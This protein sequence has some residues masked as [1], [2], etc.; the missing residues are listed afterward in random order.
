MRHHEAAEAAW[1]EMAEREAHASKI[2]Q[3]GERLKT[4]AIVWRHSP[5]IDNCEEETDEL[6]AAVDAYEEALREVEG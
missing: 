6:V 1:K 5:D 3:L 2:K 4:A